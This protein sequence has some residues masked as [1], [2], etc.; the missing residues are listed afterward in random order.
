[1]GGIVQSAVQWSLRPSLSASSA[2][3]ARVQE[4]AVEKVGTT[5]T[6]TTGTTAAGTTATATAT[7]IGAGEP[8]RCH[9]R[10]QRSAGLRASPM[11]LPSIST[12]VWLGVRVRRY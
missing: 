8:Q 7:M 5:T 12:G 10:A 11:I 4:A 6:G 3:L 1:M 2:E 9:C